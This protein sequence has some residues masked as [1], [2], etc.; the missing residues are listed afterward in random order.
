MNSTLITL[1]AGGIVFG[2]AFIFIKLAF[3]RARAL[4]RAEAETEAQK[5]YAEVQERI[6]DIAL[7]RRTSDDLRKKLR[8]KTF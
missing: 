8:D 1:I 3:A 5:T 7:E 4:G 2:L 6:N